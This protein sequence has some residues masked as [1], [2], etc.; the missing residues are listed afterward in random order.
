MRVADVATA[1]SRGVGRRPLRAA[2][3]LVGLV[4]GVASTLLVVAVAGGASRSAV[5]AIAGLGPNLVVIFPTGPSDS[6]VQAG[7]GTSSITDADVVALSDPATVPDSRQAVPTTG[8]T[9]D[10]ASLDRSWRTDVIGTTTGF[11]PVRGYGISSGRSFNDAEAQSG[12]S[13]AVVGQTLVDNLFAGDDPVG[14]TIRINSHPFT[15]VGVLAARGYSGTFNQDDLVTLPITAARAYVLPP[16]VAPV[17]QVLLQATSQQTAG[18]VKDEATATLLQRHQITD[19][20]KA[21]FQVHTQQDLVAGADRV[22]HVLR[23]MLLVVAIVALLTGTLAIASLMLAAVGE[24]RYEIGIRRAV[25]ARRGEILVQFL[26][27][28]LLL[29]VV[30]GAIGITIAVGAAGFIGSVVSDLPTPVVSLNAV[31][32]AAG[33]ALAVGLL[34]GAYPALRA[35]QLEPAEAVRRI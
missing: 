33:A 15:V 2:L 30:G 11:A 5:A 4:I 20:A 25:G 14:R 35:A 32:I 26:A 7:L 1:A 12:A 24:R 8:V 18:A 29:A 6:G 31:L 21:D 9:T 16:S 19:P 34:S 17:Q 10:V 3:T 28:A 23:V 13:V 27:E 22:S